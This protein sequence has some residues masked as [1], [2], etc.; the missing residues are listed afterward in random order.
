MGTIQGDPAHTNAAANG[1]ARICTLRSFL[2]QWSPSYT[3]ANGPACLSQT[4]V[5]V[6]VVDHTADQT[7]FPSHVEQWMDAAGSRGRLERLR[8]APHYLDDKPE[9]KGRLPG[10][11]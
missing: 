7:T 6:L 1:L 4:R 2:S 3:R 9:L 10:C 11:S 8:G 5:P